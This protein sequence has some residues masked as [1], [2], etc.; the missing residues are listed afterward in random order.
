MRLRLLTAVALF[1]LAT[2]GRLAAAAPDEPAGAAQ[3]PNQPIVTYTRQN[4]FT[5]PF[6]IE[7][8]QSP[9]QQPVEVQLHVSTNQATTWELAS[10]VKPE[11]GAFVFRAPHDGEYWYS[12]RTVDKQGVARPEGPLEPQLKVTV[13][14]VAPRLD[15]S[16]FRGDAGEIVARWQAVD[17]H[18][19]PDTFKL[20]YQT[21]STGPW[22]RVAVAQPPEAMRHTLSGEAT[23]WPK[24]GIDAVQVR[25]E[26]TDLSGNPA[27]SQATVKLGTAAVNAETARGGDATRAERSATDATH[28]PADRS[29]RDPLARS[30][31]PESRAN[32]A[33]N[34]EPSWRGRGSNNA[35]RGSGR[36]LPAQNVSQN[37]R[38]V[39][40]SLD[41]SVLPAGARPRMV[42][43]RSFELEYEVDSVGPSGISKVELW[44]TR[45]GGRTWSVFGTDTDHRSPMPIG[46]D[47][48]GIYGFRVVVQSGSG[49]G[50]RPPTEGDLPDIWIGVDLTNP[51]GRITSADVDPETSEL[52]IHWEA[53]DDV[54][55]PR[56]I[57]LSFSASAQG[58]WTPIASGLENTGSYRWR[59]DGRVPDRIYLRLEVRDEA[60]NVGTYDTAEP[61]ALDRHR[62][63]GRIRGVRPLGP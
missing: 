28:W 31:D 54:P 49:L 63:A 21:N 61:V 59:L 22:E 57:S 4:A 30:A 24:G 3:P 1:L 2:T 43:S 15:L 14:T 50:G 56:P 19:K 47:A 62:P 16:A 39:R 6:R 40:S 51:V 37:L 46:V 58:P 23:W 26:V 32:D 9:G 17:P 29:T 38:G 52:T 12:I 48:E 10:R 34:R 41:F 13:D 45:D 53:G 36:H 44:G 8:P 35:D 11:K 20:E 18:L 60:G 27:V 42:N 25:A 7:A 55:D 5:I 33:W